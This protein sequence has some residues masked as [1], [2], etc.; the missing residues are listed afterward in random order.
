MPETHMPR[1]QRDNPIP[2]LKIDGAAHKINVTA[3]SARNAT[4]FDSKTRVVSIYATGGVYLKQGG[5]DVS[6]TTNDHFFPAGLY[7]DIAIGSDG[8]QDFSA[9][10]AFVKA[11]ADCIV[12]LSEKS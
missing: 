3:A 12:Y 9:Y 1:D 2:C 7:Y 8:T 4:A 11:D 6:A 10:I 5:S